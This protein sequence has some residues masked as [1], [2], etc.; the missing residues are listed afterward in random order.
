MWKRIPFAAANLKTAL[1][2]V[3]ANLGLFAVAL[4]VSAIAMG[5]STLWFL[6]FGTALQTESL[7]VVFLLFLSYYWTHEVLR[8]TVHVTTAVSVRA[9]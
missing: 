4:I 6:G 7:V 2:A 9:Y 1:L 8:N 3:K 5:W